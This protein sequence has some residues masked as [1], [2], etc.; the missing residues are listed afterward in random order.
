MPAAPTAL[1]AQGTTAARPVAPMAT[2]PWSKGEFLEYTLKVG[3]LEAGSGRMMVLGLDTLRGRTAWRLRF[4][5]TGGIPGVRIDDSYD[6]FLD[7][8]S[9]NSLRFVQDLNELGNAKLR[10]YDIFPDR[11]LFLEHGKGERPSVDAPL[12]DASFFFFLRTIPLDVGKRYEFNRYFDPNANPVV[13]QVLRKERVTV[14]AGTFDAIVIRPIIKTSGLFAEGG[15]AEIWLSDDERH[16][17]LRMNVKLGSI[18]SLSLALRKMQNV[19]PLRSTN[20]NDS[21]KRP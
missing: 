2:V 1:L 11:K 20:P 15:R 5:I 16:L 8:Q 19:M 21:T 6:S 10:I 12:D 17:L 14:P 4:N 13:I 3:F 7:T 18:A 9:L